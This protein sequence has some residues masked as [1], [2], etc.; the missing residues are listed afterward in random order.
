MIPP[1]L[2]VARASSLHKLERYGC[3]LGVLCRRVTRR[4]QLHSTQLGIYHTLIS[5]HLYSTPFAP[6]YYYHALL[7]RSLHHFFQFSY[8]PRAGRP[9]LTQHARARRSRFTDNGLDCGRNNAPLDCKLEQM[10]R[11][12]VG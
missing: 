12:R 8:P 2:L 9:V 3:G 11:Q 10:R 5:T 4:G 6:L 1:L 7:P